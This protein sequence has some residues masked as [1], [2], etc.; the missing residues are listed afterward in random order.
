LRLR[1]NLKDVITC[2]IEFIL[3]SMEPD[4]SLAMLTY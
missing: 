2:G 1:S 4:V 3:P